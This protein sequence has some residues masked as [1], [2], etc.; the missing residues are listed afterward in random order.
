MR[1]TLKIAAAIAPLILPGCNS[2]NSSTPPPT[3]PSVRSALDNVGEEIH[4][5]LYR[6]A[7]AADDNQRP[8]LERMALRKQS[9]WDSMRIAEIQRRMANFFRFHLEKRG[10]KVTTHQGKTKNG[11]TEMWISAERNGIEAYFR[12][13]YLDAND[14]RK[15]QV[16]P[17]FKYTDLQGHEHRKDIPHQGG[18]FDTVDVILGHIDRESRN[19]ERQLSKKN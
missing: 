11:W 19:I 2:G 10:F 16:Y 9:E 6:V 15:I 13:R 14:P 17:T 1:K 5:L 7:W 8:E 4:W 3:H 18:I 12:I